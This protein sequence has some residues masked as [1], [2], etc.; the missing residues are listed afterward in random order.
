M[1][2]K[3]VL[4]IDDDRAMVKTLCAVL[5]LHGW[6]PT[7]G[8]NAEDAIREARGGTFAAVI[9]DVC[10]P[11]LSGVEAFRVI[12]QEY[13]DLPIML[14][15]AYANPEL[16]AQAEREGVL[17]I[18]PKPLPL[19]RLT[20]TLAELARGG[21]ILVLDDE[22]EFLKTIASI[23]SAKHHAVLRATR[24]EDALALLSDSTARVIVMDL[25]LGDLTP[26][27]AVVAVKRVSPEVLLILYSG[28]PDLLDETV[29]TLPAGWVYATLHKP[30]APDR[31]L[32]LLN[33][34]NRDQLH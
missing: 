33:G 20:E 26:K 6:D 13:P 3:S 4:V 34:I 30:F 1:M 21:P 31:L 18:L 5:R 16:L 32:E 25:K 7:A 17:M 23:L 14:M 29:A 2:T 27:D 24:L 9:M 10:M 15:T 19:P 28:Y 8:Y 11:G 12:R 22:P